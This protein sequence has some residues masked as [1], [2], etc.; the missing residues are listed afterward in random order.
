MHPRGCGLGGGLGPHKCCI[1]GSLDPRGCGLG[2]RPGSTRVWPGR[3][4]RIHT[5]AVR[6]Q[7]GLGWALEGVEVQLR[8]PPLSPCCTITCSFLASRSSPPSVVPMFFSL[9]SPLVSS[10]LSPLVPLSKRISKIQDDCGLGVSLDPL[11]CGVGG[12][13]GSTR[14][15]PGRS[16]RI[17][18]GA[19]WAV[20]QDPHRRG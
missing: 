18:A 1:F 20:S 6:A 3:S 9:L 4:A 2:V 10:S 11:R 5:G 14:V 12:L 7:G 17:H 15:R 8:I 13:P 16:A 19:A